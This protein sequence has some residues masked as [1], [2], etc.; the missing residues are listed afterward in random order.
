MKGDKTLSINRLGWI[1]VAFVAS[2]CGALVPRVFQLD[3][4]AAAPLQPVRSTSFELLDDSGRKKAIIESE[5]GGSVRLRF[6][7]AEMKTPLELGLNSGG[8]PFLRINGSDGRVRLTLKLIEGD[9]P[10]ILMGDSTSEQRLQLG[11]TQP[12]AT[13]SNSDV[14]ALL[15]G[16]PI[17]R[18]LLAGLA[19]NTGPGT[20]AGI[21]SLSVR[22]SDGKRWDAPVGK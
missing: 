9:K 5:K 21:G 6:F 18:D 17:D 7:D 12:D 3:A 8:K 16:N 19:M 13:G 1:F 22:N 14:W 11:A 20:G 4:A 2:L 15:L 10:T